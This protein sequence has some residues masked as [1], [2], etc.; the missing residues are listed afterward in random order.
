[1]KKLML[2]AI[3]LAFTAGMTGCHKEEATEQA[4]PPVK[5]QAV[6]PVSPTTA[7]P[8]S[9]ATAPAAPAK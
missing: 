8:V 2:L 9:P 5:T 3:V 6:A 1:M 7:A 4:A